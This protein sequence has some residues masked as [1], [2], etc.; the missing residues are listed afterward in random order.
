MDDAAGPVGIARAGD[1]RRADRPVPAGLRGPRAHSSCWWPASCL[2]CLSRT[3]RWWG[4]FAILLPAA[5]GLLTGLGMLVNMLTTGGNRTSALSVM[6]LVLWMIAAGYAANQG[7]QNRLGHPPAKTWR[8][9]IPVL[10]AYAVVTPAPTAVGR[11]LFAPELRDV[12]IE[13]QGNTVGLRMAAL[14]TAS[15]CLGLPGWV[16][17]RGHHLG[18]VSVVADAARI[19]GDGADRGHRGDVPLH[20]AVGWTASSLAADR[21]DHLR[22]ESP[23][24]EPIFTCGALELDRSRRSRPGRWRSLAQD[25]TPSRSSRAT[26]RS[27]PRLFR[28]PCLRWRPRPPR[29]VTL[30]ARSSR[31]STDRCSLPGPPTGWTRRSTRCSG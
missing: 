26:G 19:A 9:G 1:R 16:V 20:G 11:W 10:L 6:L 5:V 4:R 22:S 18:H 17:G 15:S 24:S 25:A 31:R 2:V 23:A 8:S 7:L 12:A 3:R 29:A 27:S 30:P 13:L 14:W 21:V 28:C